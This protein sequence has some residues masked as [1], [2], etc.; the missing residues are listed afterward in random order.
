MTIAKKYALL[1]FEESAK[2]KISPLVGKQL[3]A[4]EQAICQ[5]PMI[6][7]FFLS[8]TARKEKEALLLK[9]INKYDIHPL[10]GSLMKQIIKNDR[11]SLLSEILSDYDLLI[12]NKQLVQITSAKTI[13]KKDQSLVE[14][15]AQKEFGDN[16]EL[17][18]KID[19]DLIGGIVMRYGNTLI[20]AS[21]TGA[22]KRTAPSYK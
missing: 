2:N 14:A 4:L 22:L 5:D 21:I 1:L 19:K 9:V 6:L 20:D 8:P 7:Q 16:L 11:I 12:Q 10:V 15:M 17:E 3:S 13:E 18:Y